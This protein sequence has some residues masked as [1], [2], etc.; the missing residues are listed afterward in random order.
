M[1]Y[2]FCSCLYV[3]E[4]M[5]SA[6]IKGNRNVLIWA[7]AAITNIVAVASHKIGTQTYTMA[8]IKLDEGQSYYVDFT[9]ITTYQETRIRHFPSEQINDEQKRRR[10]R[11]KSVCFSESYA[12]TNTSRTET[13][14]SQLSINSNDYKWRLWVSLQ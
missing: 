7:N 3:S 10:R 4:S 1:W 14:T 6:T 13:Q 9:W 8:T 5:I 11:E 2:H 12:R